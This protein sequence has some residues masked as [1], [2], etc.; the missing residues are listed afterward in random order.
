LNISLRRIGK[1]RTD[2]EELQDKL[3]ESGRS[4]DLAAGSF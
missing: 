2:D 1:I 3:R 4:F